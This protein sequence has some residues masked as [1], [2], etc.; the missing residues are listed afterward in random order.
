MSQP[1][2]IG[3]PFAESEIKCK[4]V[5]MVGIILFAMA[6]SCTSASAEF[7]VYTWISNWISDNIDGK[8]VSGN[9]DA[10]NMLINASEVTNND[11]M[12]DIS[13]NA[14][15]YIKG[16]IHIASKDLVD[17]NNSTYIPPPEE[18]ARIFGEAGITRNDPVVVYGEC[19]P[20]GGG[21]S[22]ATYVYWMLRY[23]GHDDVKVLNG[24][25]DA[26]EKAGL[27]VQNA[28]ST[29]LATNYVPVLRPE[30]FATYDY[31]KSGSA[32][33]VDA[34]SVP[35][36]ESGSVPGALNIPYSEVL[37]GKSI[38]DRADLEEV[39]VN[40]TKEKPVVVFTMTGL[41]ASMVW[42]SLT[43]MGY[44]AKLYTW[45]DWIKNRN[46]ITKKAQKT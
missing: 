36:F 12:L 46:A 38:K 3:K 29:R 16:A 2:L 6:I 26:W 31:V 44:E 20:C 39:F 35:E 25:I 23:I 17:N 14:K 21:P 43:M 42:F 22:A 41:K 11:I 5:R 4:H 28:S 37:K 9:V 24:G 30:L 19:K 8:A 32:Q 7:S 13:E 27:P 15:S 45:K 1:E 10:Q 34:R 18:I 33:I 40:L